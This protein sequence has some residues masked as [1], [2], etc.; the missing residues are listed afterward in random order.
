MISKK[1]DLINSIL[2]FHLFKASI[3]EC[4]GSFHVIYDPKKESSNI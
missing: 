4:M 1:K 3:L 2:R